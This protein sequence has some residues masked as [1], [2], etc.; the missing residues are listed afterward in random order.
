M[1]VA[2]VTSPFF[3]SV[4]TT[5]ADTPSAASAG[6][7]ARP[8]RASSAASAA[9][10]R[11]VAAAAARPAGVSSAMRVVLNAWSRP[12]ATGGSVSASVSPGPA[13]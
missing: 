4:A 13:A 1:A 12:R 2:I 11:G 6:M 3:A 10:W 5:A 9:R 8:P 7:G